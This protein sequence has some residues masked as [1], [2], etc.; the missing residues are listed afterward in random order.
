MQCRFY[1]NH[2][3][4]RLFPRLWRGFWPFADLFL[5]VLAALYLLASALLVL[6]LKQ[7]KQRQQKQFSL[8]PVAGLAEIE[9][10]QR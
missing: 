2:C 1:C 10:A 3:Y 8:V 4:T 5:L 7:A 6:W 9:E